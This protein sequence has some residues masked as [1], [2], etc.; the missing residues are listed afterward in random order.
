M[1][2]M[3]SRFRTLEVEDCSTHQL[4]PQQSRHVMSSQDTVRLILNQ[5][6]RHGR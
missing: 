5:F 3:W 2:V 1:F 6:E 4:V